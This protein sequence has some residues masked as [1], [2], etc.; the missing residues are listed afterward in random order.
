[1][2]SGFAS[3]ELLAAITSGVGLYRAE[4]M[5]RQSLDHDKELHVREVASNT[6]QHF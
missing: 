2:A 3:M 6:E 4:R 5:H 1:M